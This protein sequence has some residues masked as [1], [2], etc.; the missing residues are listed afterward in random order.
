MGYPW[1][2]KIEAKGCQSERKF[3]N[4]GQN[5]STKPSWDGPVRAPEAPVVTLVAIFGCQGPAVGDFVHHF[6]VR[7]AARISR[8]LIFVARCF[9][10]III[11]F[12]FLMCAKLKTIS[13]VYYL[14]PTS[15]HVPNYR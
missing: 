1:A 8:F 5:V 7:L 9:Y 6:V 2:P 10:L 11:F 13:P 15:Y 4:D 12:G 14:F 3:K